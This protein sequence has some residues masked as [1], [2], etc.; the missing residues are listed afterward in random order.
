M[1][2]PADP[3][4]E[5]AGPPGAEG[6]IAGGVAGGIAGG[7]LVDAFGGEAVPLTEEMEPPV[8]LSGRDPEWTRDAI[9]RSPGGLGVVRCVVSREGVLRDCRI[10]KGVAFMDEQILAALQTHRYRPAMSGGRPV[11]VHYVLKFKLVVPGR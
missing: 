4:P 7:P 3:S 9:E 6:G 10:L 8:R 1:P 2:A 5:T 11:S